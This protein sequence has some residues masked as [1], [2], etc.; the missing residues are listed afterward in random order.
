MITIANMFTNM[1]GTNKMG[2]FF[3]S[4]YV[5]IYPEIWLLTTTCI[6][7]ILDVFL[8]KNTKITYY[9]S[10]IILLVSLILSLNLLGSG[11]TVL[12]DSFI[13][14]D[15]G[16]LLKVILY[17]VGIFVFIYAH[18]Y[19]EERNMAK[20]EY[21]I[22][23]LFSILGMLVLISSYSLLTL[24]LGVELLALPLY[25]LI[26][27]RKDPRSTEAAM[28]YF[29]LGALASGM[30]LYGISLLYGVT[31]TFEI[32]ALSTQLNT[33][34][35]QSHIALLFGMIFTLVGLAFKLGAVPFHM[36]VPDIYEGSGTAATLFIA[37]LPELAGFG[38]A[39]R[40]LLNTFSSLA[41]D[42]QQ[43]W[44]IMAVLSLVV[45]NIA[46]IAQTNLKRMLAY[47]A[48]SHMGFVFLGL[49]SGPVAGFAPAMAYI[50]IYV[51]MALAAFGIIIM[52]SHEGFEAENIT[53]FKG[54]G[55]RD[56]WVA[57][58]MLLVL[59]SL[60]G[61]PPLLGF[62]AKFL[63]L[64]ALIQAGYVWLAVVAVIFAVIGAF[65]YLRVIRVMFFDAPSKEIEMPFPTWSKVQGFDL[66]IVSINGLILLALGIYPA[67]LINA[68]LAVFKH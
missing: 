10:L 27:M 38:M 39:I 12:F 47:S 21:Y 57:L 62:Y 53:D 2:D 37:T 66:T 19:L 15:I 23:C 31:G 18:R 14:D 55:R 30:M 3:L 6:L 43:V 64:D 61:I 42:W 7:I 26:A 9:F 32:K 58:M 63:I 36:W 8:H 4:S 41:N 5:S 49:L 59:F 60:A 33:T 46:A 51:L 54:L 44:L 67:P 13:Q 68:C 25:A 50:I 35:S 20:G 65:Y 24:Y 34:T 1:I 11:T 56:P 17:L 52:L 40:L 45:G 22:L 29:V 48:I 16:N 28:K